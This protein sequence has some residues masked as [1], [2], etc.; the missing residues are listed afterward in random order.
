MELTGV[1]FGERFGG[2]GDEASWAALKSNVGI[3]IIRR[4]LTLRKPIR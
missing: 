2:W 3:H 1:L 4:H